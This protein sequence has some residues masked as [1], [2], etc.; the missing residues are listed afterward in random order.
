MLLLLAISLAIAFG[1]QGSRGIYAPD[2]GYYVSV[3]QEMNDSGDYLVPRSHL[4]PWL[5]KPPL[6]SWGI[7]AGMRLLGQN[8]WGARAFHGLCYV[9]T[10][11]LVYSLGR[12]LG[13]RRE[14]LL[15]G[16]I[17][18]TMIIPAAAANTITPD[19][20]LVLWTTAALLCFWKSVQRNARSVFLWK[21]LM[22][23]A[24][25][26][27]FL[28][29][30]PAAVIPAGAMFVFLVLQRRVRE[31]LLAPWVLPG[32]LLFC[33]TG[34]AWYFY[35][36]REIPGAFDYFVDNLFI[37]RTVSAKY[38][39]N[40]GIEGILLYLAVVVA[41]TLPWS[42]AWWPSLWQRRNRLLTREGWRVLRADA[43]SL[44]LFTW[45]AVFMIVLCLARSKLPLYALPVLPAMALV[46]ARMRIWQRPGR[47]WTS[48]RL[49]LSRGAL[50][51]LVLSTAILLGLKEAAAHL[52]YR[53][54]MRALYASI[55]TDLAGDSREIAAVDDHLDG[56]G[57]YTASFVEQVTMRKI[58]YP[59]FVLPEPLSTEVEE[60]RTSG[61]S[62]MFICRGTAR[63]DSIRQLLVAAG[64]RFRERRLAF[65]RYAFVC[66]PSREAEDIAR[67]A[68][69]GGLRCGNGRSRQYSI[70]AQLWLAY[71]EG[72]FKD[73]VILLGDNL[74]SGKRTH[75][76]QE[77]VP[78]RRFERPFADLI[79]RA[80]PFYAVLG[81]QDYVD[82]SK[83]FELQY[84]L[85]NMMGRRYY[86]QKLRDGLVELF[87]LDSSSLESQDDQTGTSDPEQLD[88]L[89][90]G[91]AES[92]ASWKVVA[93]HQPLYSTAREQASG[94]SLAR[95]LGPIF[96][97]YGV[98]LVLQGHNRVYERLKPI[99][100]VVYITCGNAVSV[101]RGSLEPGNEMRSAG[102]DQSVGLA[103]VEFGPDTCKV[104]A[105]DATGNTVDE[106]LILPREL[107]PSIL[108]SAAP[109][110]P[111]I[112]DHN[113]MLVDAEFQR[114]DGSWRK[115]RLWIDTGNPD[116]FMS[117][118]L[119]RDLGIDLVAAD[120]ASEKVPA[121]QITPPQGVRIGGMPLDFSGVNSIVLFTPGWLFSTTHC[122]A[123]LPSTVLSR[124]EV[125]FDYPALLVTIAPPGEL[126]P[127]GTRA[128][129][130]VD[131]KT[132]IVQIDALV[133]GDT[134]SFAL[135]NGASFSFT[136]DDV[137]ERWSRR[138]PDWARSAGGLGYANIWGWW[139]GEPEW[140]LVRVPEISWGGVT[141]AG[142][143]IAGLPKMFPGGMA[144]GEWYSQKTARPVDGILGPN[145]FKAFRVEIDFA[146]AAVYFEKR[147]PFDTA[148][149]DLVGLTLRPEDDGSYSV[150]GVAAKDGQP[151]VRD[152]KPGDK[153]LEV[154]GLKTT[155]A[156]MGTVIDA[157][158]GRPGDLRRL[159]LERGGKRY[160]VEAQVVRFL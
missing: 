145:A 67:V 62:T 138:H 46:T 87:V 35:I 141:L 147:A 74:Y 89:R 125:A 97:R 78:T 109:S 127:R 140:P 100:D 12:S 6:D 103:T 22:C 160:S 94:P 31:Y 33:V 8:E 29:K 21:M 60:A 159:V 146:G 53:K 123:N 32:F 25:G 126:T 124:Y 52:P 93:I 64:L 65:S 30:G 129:A 39:R 136:S 49:G 95:L 41:G 102:N 71:T 17:F 34:L 110:V 43:A 59:F 113:R 99:D 98:S 54:D 142:V 112:L 72:P 107:L 121:L 50:V 85:F 106:A 19:T 2:E 27:G 69:V 108:P 149:M 101:D 47:V 77:P 117:E 154:G 131:A 82:G 91:L 130:T 153:L 45:I 75:W 24:F 44:F 23:A 7:A 70:A 104:V 155:G 143:G 51:C 148:D 116:F 42:L 57:L 132:G 76:E 158:R 79:E 144:L 1:F 122:D 3:A 92:R 16:A 15:A 84:P 137:L 56:L 9:L 134:L 36:A 20:P 48:N 37:G 11:L 111:M 80:V 61:I 157:L 118:G 73:G 10:T 63:A 4:Q 5:D 139:P 81:E 156:T 55:K 114:K 83:E 152:V 26:L 18:T 133:D 115:A 38:D 135:D 13:S 120:T 68:L 86:S 96:S 128:P 150:L 66:E 88:W 14:G 58:P 119:A 28:T 90:A 151:A 105:Y 40:P